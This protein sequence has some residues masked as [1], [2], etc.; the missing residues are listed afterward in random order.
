MCFYYKKKMNKKIY[1]S[2]LKNLKKIYTNLKT[3]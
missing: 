3:F 1:C 2:K